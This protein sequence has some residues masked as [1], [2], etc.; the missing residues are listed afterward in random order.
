MKL[1]R[2]LAS[3]LPLL[4]VMAG[5]AAAAPKPPV[6]TCDPGYEPV[7]VA[8]TPTPAQPTSTPAATATAT[9]TPTAAA[10]ATATAAPSPTG[11]PAGADF[12]LTPGQ[13]AFGAVATGSTSPAQMVRIDTVTGGY[14]V[15]IA[16]SPPFARADNN[17]VAQGGWDGVLAPGSHCDFGVVYSPTATGSDAGTATVASGT[18]AR[19]VALS[20]QGAAPATPSPTAAAP[21]PTNTPP[22]APTATTAPPPTLPPPTAGPS[23]TAPSV[24]AQTPIPPQRWVDTTLPT[25]TGQ[26]RI[27]GEGGNLQAAL[28]AAVPGDAVTVQA[29][30]TFSGKFW[31]RAK[32]QTWTT[33]VLAAVGLAK[34]KVVWL[35]S[36]TWQTSLPPVGTR[37]TKAD[38]PKMP[39]LINSGEATLIAEVGASNYFLTG[40]EI[41]TGWTNGTVDNSWGLVTLGIDPVSGG[42]ITTLAGLPDNI[43]LDRVWI[44]GTTAGSNRRGITANTR[45]FAVVDSIIDEIHSYGKD[46]QAVGGWNAD[47]PIKLI[48]NDLSAAGEVV[49]WGGAD[50]SIANLTPTDFEIR[51]NLFHWPSEW[52]APVP[53]VGDPGSPNWNGSQWSLKNLFEMKHGKQMIISGNVFDGWWASGQ[54]CPLM[55]TVR[56]QSGTNPWA[57]VRDL[58]FD[59]NI[60]RNIGPGTCAFNMFGRDNPGSGGGVSEQT[61]RVQ[62]VNNYISMTGS[63][64]LTSA[65]RIL[66]GTDSTWI[67][68]NTLEMNKD[69]TL[70]SLDR[71]NGP[72]TNMVYRNNIGALGRYGVACTN[73]GSGDPALN[74]CAPGVDFRGNL[75]YG[76]YPTSGGADPNTLSGHPGNFY[77][78]NYAAVGIDPSTH[79]LAAGS[80]WKG[81][82]TNGGDSGILTAK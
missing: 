29:G 50:A 75:I 54:V 44:H 5:T 27:V 6:V 43:I 33:T 26:D 79:L 31:L 40:L 82:A 32:A 17:C 13:L 1:L 37:V 65:F 63:P 53:S 16:V 12:T 41:T 67:E 10:T 77:P 64:A 56:N 71:G 73:T 11:P 9:R 59:D 21:T 38:A 7:C 76:P 48:N 69:S 51:G 15:S 28:D 74:A 8:Y 23:P 52:H 62:V 61:V 36:S 57:T 49:M 18:A 34:P 39:R 46:S 72:N 68:N 22:P 30:A 47:G 3:L 60:V 35:R 70:L 42:A 45:S 58:K 2:W 4:L 81:K 80:A 66:G 55:I 24:A 20:G 78:A 19:A 25:V 14:A